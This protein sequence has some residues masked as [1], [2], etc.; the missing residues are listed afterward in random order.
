MLLNLLISPNSAI[1]I[2][3]VNS[4]M[5]NI[6]LIDLKY[7]DFFARNINLYLIVSI[8]FGSY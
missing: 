5:P 7:F 6:E 4:P 1:K 8:S 2:E 3:A